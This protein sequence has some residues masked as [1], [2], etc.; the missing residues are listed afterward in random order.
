MREFVIY[1]IAYVYAHG[2]G[3]NLKVGRRLTAPELAA[4]A[5]RELLDP[6]GRGAAR[7]GDRARRWWG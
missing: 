1:W 2:L 4:I 6:A 5:R 3:E 7:G